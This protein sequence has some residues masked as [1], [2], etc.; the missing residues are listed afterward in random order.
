MRFQS[1]SLAA[2]LFSEVIAIPCSAIGWATG[3]DGSGQVGRDPFEQNAEWDVVDARQCWVRFQTHREGQNPI[4]VRITKT[5]FEATSSQVRHTINNYFGST[6]NIMLWLPMR[7]KSLQ[8]ANILSENLGEDF[9]P[10][11]GQS[12]IVKSRTIVSIILPS[13]REKLEEVSASP[14]EQEESNENVVNTERTGITGLRGQ[15]ATEDWAYTTATEL[16]LVM[17][18]IVYEQQRAYVQRRAANMRGFGWLTAEKAN[19]DCVVLDFRNFNDYVLRTRPA[20][21]IV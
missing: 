9:E 1:V 18:G 6:G 12:S 4:D 17:F 2:A 20:A 7:T 15:I 8:Y 14:P 5:N 13:G 16:Q 19:G 10:V 21:D 3:R 11:A